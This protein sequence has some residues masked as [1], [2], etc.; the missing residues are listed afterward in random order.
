MNDSIILTNQSI[1]FF[2]HLFGLV[3]SMGYFILWRKF[4]ELSFSFSFDELN[5]VPEFLNNMNSENQTIFFEVA[6]QIERHNNRGRGKE[7]N[8]S[9]VSVF[10]IDIDIVTPLRKL[11]DMPQSFDEALILLHKI[12][13]TPVS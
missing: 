9:V 3:W 1:E 2:N 10:C 4:D 5:K 7:E 13:L 8:V 6:L 12:D 11:K